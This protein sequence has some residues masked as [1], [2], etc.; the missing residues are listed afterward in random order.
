MEHS[1]SVSTLVELMA[2]F[3]ETTGPSRGASPA[4]TISL[5]RRLCRLQFPRY[6]QSDGRHQVS[7]SGAAARGSGPSHP[8]PATWGRPQVRVDQ[9][10]GRGGR[11][12]HPTIGGLRIGKKLKERG[13]AEP[14]DERVEW[15][16]DG[17]YFHYLTKWMHALNRV[18][19]ALGDPVYNTWAVELAK[20]AHKHFVYTPPG[21]GRKRMYWKMSSDLSY[22]LV[23][24]MGH[25]DPLDGF[26]TY[27]QLQDVAE[28]SDLSAEIADMALI[29]EGKNWTTDDPLGLGGLLS[30]AFKVAQLTVRGGIGQPG[31][32]EE[33]LHCVLRGLQS[34]IRQN[35]LT[36]PADYRLAFG[37]WDY[38][39]ASRPRQNSSGSSKSIRLPS[40]TSISWH[41]R[42]KACWNIRPLPKPSSPSGWSLKTGEA[43]SGSN[44]ARS[45]WSCWPP[46]WLRTD[47][48]SYEGVTRATTRKSRPSSVT[49]LPALLSLKVLQLRQQGRLR[50]S[51]PKIHAAEFLEF[52]LH[53]FG[54]G[55]IRLT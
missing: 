9:R 15:D 4:E 41:Y 48:C 36:L 49:G 12:K 50:P 5:D 22:P 46:T 45:I 38:P 53:S 30:D 11:Q 26:V 2:D 8:R 17:Q 40:R 21:G 19:R 28:A 20:T 42:S 1:A 29:C 31:L 27:H 10:A 7:G 32:L 13:P 43:A 39:S 14:Y 18:T 34:F 24:S 47:T 51:G 35:L 6:L 3:A 25:H 44:T 55:V 52:L 33:L 16:R 37:N 23:S 54:V